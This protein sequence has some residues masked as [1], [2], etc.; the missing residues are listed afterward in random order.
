MRERYVAD[1]WTSFSASNAKFVKAFKSAQRKIL[2]DLKTTKTVATM[3]KMRK[4][5]WFEKFAW[6]ISSENYLVIAGR[7]MQQN[8]T[9]V[10]KYLGKSMLQP[11]LL[12]FASD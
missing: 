4:P 8:E 2:Q 5:Y 11:G 12:N 3:N 9:L 1:G 10:K 7:D 6:F